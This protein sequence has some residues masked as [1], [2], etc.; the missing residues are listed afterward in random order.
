M[1]EYCMPFPSAPTVADKITLD[2]SKESAT[3]A[4][5]R[6]AIGPLNSDYYLPIFS[7]FESTAKMALKWNTAASLYTLNWML[8]RR[9]WVAALVYASAILGGILVVF[10]LGRLIFQFSTEV[11]FALGLLMLILSCVVP[12]LFGNTWL[13]MDCRRRMAQAL[14]QSSTLQEACGKLRAQSSSRN[15]FIGMVAVNLILI[16][17]VLGLYL[18]PEGTV[19]IKDRPPLPVTE[20]QPLPKPL[21]L[22]DLTSTEPIAAVIQTVAEPPQPSSPEPAPAPE[23]P[24]SAS[25]PSSPPTPAPTPPPVQEAKPIAAKPSS[26]SSYYVNV[27]LFANADNAE[28]VHQR[29]NNAGMAVTTEVLVLPKGNRSRVRVG[30]FPNRSAADEA[31]RTVKALGLDAIVHSQ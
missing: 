8:F 18:K 31:V 15:R 11:G 28:K 6:A 9:L 23:L 21:P 24:L 2:T 5:Y 22:V 16:S 17:V 14:S 1:P 19:E 3:Q 13:H 20:L 27:G 25:V 7:G 12:G 10:G 4:L 29:L 30:P 26:L